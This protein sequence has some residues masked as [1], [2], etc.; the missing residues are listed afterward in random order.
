MLFSEKFACISCGISYPEIT[1]RMFSFNNPQ[2]ACP[3]CDGIGAKLFFDPDLIVP[4]RGAVAASEGAIDPWEKRNT[5]FFQQILDAV[6]THFR[7]TCT[8]RGPSCR[9]SSAS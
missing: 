5:P 2:G 1:P 9:R 3:N 7:S 4:R 6:A 8:R